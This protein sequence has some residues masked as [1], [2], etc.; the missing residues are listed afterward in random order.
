MR[1]MSLTADVGELLRETEVCCDYTMHVSAASLQRAGLQVA[2]MWS[3]F[4]NKN[5]FLMYY[6]QK[7][8]VKF[9]CLHVQLLQ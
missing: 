6:R 4:F 1:G 9:N 5:E 8:S 7:T 3:F 2:G